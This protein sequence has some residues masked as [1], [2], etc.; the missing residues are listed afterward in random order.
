MM[1]FKAQID[2][3]HPKLC[4][5][6]Q[7]G[8][9]KG[10]ETRFMYSRKSFE[11]KISVQFIKYG[12]FVCMISKNSIADQ[13]II[14]SPSWSPSGLWRSASVF[15]VWKWASTL[16]RGRASS[17][18]R[19]RTPVQPRICT[20]PFYSESF[21]FF[22]RQLLVFGCWW[23]FPMEKSFKACKNTFF[24]CLNHTIVG[25]VILGHFFI[26]LCWLS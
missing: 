1:M 7:R 14:S 12:G 10:R 4:L 20:I 13:L 21:S 3:S 11:N 25:E 19:W 26:G 24:K 9:K 6:C 5:V 15:S 22:F 8:K 23:L 16:P 17:H 18:S 2:S